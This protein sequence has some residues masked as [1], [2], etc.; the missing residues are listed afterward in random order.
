MV[1]RAEDILAYEEQHLADSTQSRVYTP[2]RHQIYIY[3]AAG[4]YQ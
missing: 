3:G 2:S 1:Y 4:G